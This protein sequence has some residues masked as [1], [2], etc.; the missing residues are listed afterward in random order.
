MLTKSGGH[1][2]DGVYK[3]SLSPRQLISSSLPL[4]ALDIDHVRRERLL[5]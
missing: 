3:K 5:P 1:A 4:S 2:R